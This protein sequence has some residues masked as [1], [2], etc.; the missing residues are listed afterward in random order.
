MRARLLGPAPRDA[1]RLVRFLRA[2][3]R[4]RVTFT[5]DRRTGRFTAGGVALARARRSTACLRLRVTAGRRRVPRGS[6][7]LLGRRLRGGAS[8][9]FRLERD[10]S[11]TALGRLRV[12]AGRDRGLPRACDRLR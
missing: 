3:W 7:T 4:T 9:R 8:F 11:A 12:R 1:R 5:L 6:I 2:P 10:G